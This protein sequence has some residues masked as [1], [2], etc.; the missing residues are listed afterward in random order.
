MV[1]SPSLAAVFLEV[2]GGASTRTEA[3][4]PGLEAKLCAILEAAHT[5]HPDIHVAGETF[6]RHLG[7]RLSSTHEPLEVLGTLNT[8]DLY[9]A[10]AAAH[11]NGAAIAEIERG[12]FSWL[13][14]AMARVAGV[15]DS[16][17]LVQLLRQK[18]F[19][20]EP[21]ELPKISEYAG[22][23]S[24]GAWLRVT[25]VRMALNARRGRKR[26]AV[27]VNADDRLDGLATHA[28]PEMEYLKSRYRNEFKYAFETAVAALSARDRNLLRLHFI[29]GLNI[30]QIGAIHRVHRSTVARW[31]AQARE[32]ILLETQRLLRERL[33]L[34]NADFNSLLAL[35]K[36]ELNLSIHRYLT[37]AAQ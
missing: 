8:S 24:L 35:V 11:G 26:E 22:I 3:A 14:A 18:L 37:D 10:C 25:A 28:S 12:Y 9:L 6:A 15:E 7:G 21:D 32:S 36:S 20:A 19:A 17:D 31:I 27:H 4:A 23:G 30:D 13:H 1:P 2:L 33:G 34:D 16:S 29:D 5:A